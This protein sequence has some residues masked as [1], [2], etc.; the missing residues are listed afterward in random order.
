[1]SVG[2]HIWV[3]LTALHHIEDTKCKSRS[4][5]TGM[6]YTPIEAPSPALE[7]PSRWVEQPCRFAAPEQNAEFVKLDSDRNEVFDS[8]DPY[9][10]HYRLCH[11]I[12]CVRSIN[13]NCNF[14]L[15]TLDVRGACMCDDCG[16]GCARLLALC[17]RDSQSPTSP[18]MQPELL[19]PRQSSP[20]LK[21]Q[22][23]E[24]ATPR[25]EQTH[26]YS[27]A[28]ASA[29]TTASLPGQSASTPPRGLREQLTAH[30]A[31]DA[32]VSKTK[33][34]AKRSSFGSDGSSA[35]GGSEGTAR[36]SSSGSSQSLTAPSSVRS[37]SSS[38][39]SA[40][41]RLRRIQRLGPPDVV[42]HV[43]SCSFGLH[44]SVVEQQ[45]P[46]LYR[47]LT[48]LRDEW[49]PD[50]DHGDTAQSLPVVAVTTNAASTEDSDAKRVLPT[51]LPPFAL[52][53]I[54]GARFVGS[55]SLGSEIALSSERI[56]C[57]LETTETTTAPMPQETALSASKH[58][59]TPFDV[60]YCLA[61][62]TAH[63]S[64]ASA[65]SRRESSPSQTSVASSA[66]S[67]SS[68]R[69]ATAASE[70][71]PSAAASDATALSDARTSKE[72]RGRGTFAAAMVA[73]DFD[74][75]ASATVRSGVRPASPVGKENVASNCQSNPTKQQQTPASP[76]TPGALSAASRPS[77]DA[78][79]RVKRR[80]FESAPSLLLQ[81]PRA[82][83][84]HTSALHVEWRAADAAAVATLVEFLYTD[85][86]RLVD[87]RCAPHV[88]HLCRW[89]RLRNELL[90]TCVS[91]AIDRAPY[92]QWIPLLL[93][94]AGVPDHTRRSALLAQLFAVLDRVP[95]DETPEIL[96]HVEFEYLSVLRDVELLTRVVTKVFNAIRHVGV[97]RNVLV[98]LDLWTA[99]TLRH[100][101]SSDGA[102][103]LRSL[104]RAFAPW[105]PFI[106]VPGVQISGE[107]YYVRPKT[108]FRFG[109]FAFQVRFELDSLVLIQW[110]V[111]KDTSSS[112]SLDL[113][114]D[115]AHQDEDTTNEDA[116]MHAHDPVLSLRGEM[117]VLFR[118]AR[119]G[120]TH[121]QDVSLRYMHSARE[122]G[123][124]QPLIRSSSVT[125]RLIPVLE[126]RAVRT[127]EGL[128][129]QSQSESVAGASQGASSSADVFEPP[130]FL[131]AKFT[132][133]FFVWGHQLCN[134]YH[135]MTACTLFYS[136]P[137]GSV[138]DLVRMNVLEKMRKLPLETLVLVLESDRLRIP[139]GETTLMQV[140]TTLCFGSRHRRSADSVDYRDV[141]VVQ[142][143]FQ[144]VRWCFTDL[145]HI[146]ETL[147]RAPREYM[148]YELI[149]T[150]LRDPL[151]KFPRRVPYNAPATPY[152]AVTS[153]VEF[154]IEAGDRALS[155][156]GG[157]CFS[158][159]SV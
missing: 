22:K 102:V 74:T 10:C 87:V 112:S 113:D 63:S 51:T 88:V 58:T 155:P 52:E 90:H 69:K 157:D 92:A 66:S 77:S 44:L 30:T 4:R 72:M 2:V 75:E 21:R 7:W 103:S 147:A 84:P 83:A 67:S 96:E 20:R 111:V 115:G 106:T 104:H 151:R 129:S 62:A 93:I 130:E 8:T 121:E 49:V 39:S 61:H 97:W 142:T 16:G 55:A 145:T 159:E 23:R 9:F 24:T 158:Q 95:M 118:C 148:L 50:S 98:G 136:S 123:V 138:G 48:A 68:S 154:E 85:D 143:L 140:L 57:C 79:V 127:E 116:A 153:L 59:E 156:N 13:P 125:A 17:I 152:H 99:R 117:K 65:S 86:V 81:S 25:N 124:W 131:S 137:S 122:Y 31:S 101:R 3:S 18:T 47:K 1:M 15:T 14:L 29:A 35:F 141:R 108:L 11:W 64:T 70:P 128:P 36:S 12:L 119:S 26:D 120:P 89:L 135:Y 107:A 114:A 27:T 144:C 54:D 38:E 150:G 45:S 126:L 94:V 105:E 34:S 133:R 91:I 43:G 28:T 134:L 33:R 32:N 40:T 149:Q 19:A 109:P 71:S 42:L 100:A 56:R 139:G 6:K 46:A 5:K 41:Q 132:G 78:R 82:S 110:R 80:S 146:L 73:L 53:R 37:S 60:V 76:Q